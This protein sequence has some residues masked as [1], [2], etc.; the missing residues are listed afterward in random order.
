MP[1]VEPDD[2]RNLGVLEGH[3]YRVDVVRDDYRVPP[4]ARAGDLE[5]DAAGDVPAPAH[6]EGPHRVQ[7]P[8]RVEPRHVR[9]RVRDEVARGG[10]A[11]GHRHAGG[12]ANTPLATIAWLHPVQ[13]NKQLYL[14]LAACHYWSART[15]LA[16]LALHIAAALHHHWIRR[17]NVLRRMLSSR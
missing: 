16:L 1:S 3:E 8:G 15:L 13:P 2:L 9:L 7:V 10:A 12:A 14:I 17:D 6:R 4:G 5:R 11:R